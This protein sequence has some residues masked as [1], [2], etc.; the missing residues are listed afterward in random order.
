MEAKSMRTMRWLLMAVLVPAL[1]IGW[2]GGALATTGGDE[3]TPMAESTATIFVRQDPA[4]GTILTDPK[5][6]TLYLFTQDTTANES[7]CYDE[8]AEAWPP[9]M[10]EEPFALPFGVEGELTTVQRTDGTTQ[11]AYNGIP[12]YYF[13][14]DMAPGD[15][16]G[17]GVGDVWFVLGPDAQFGA[18]ATPEPVMAGSMGTPQA[19]GDVEV[20]VLDG[21][22]ESSITDF[23]VGETYTFNVT[24]GG[25]IEHEIILEKAGAIHEP[26]EAEGG[27]AEVEGLQAGDSG[28]FTV[29]FTEAGNYQL[30][31][32]VDGHYEAG[33][34]LTI[35]VSE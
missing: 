31:C 14:K 9:F 22:V 6:M 34:V 28:S 16:N 21:D 25:E 15:T 30:A 12:L 8:C 29:T 33:T 3:G 11:V 35:H 32:H 7:T 10:A 24:N 13:V 2:S 27:E 26:I 23:R 4:L 1:L 5:G 20:T 18:V 19:G 17:Q